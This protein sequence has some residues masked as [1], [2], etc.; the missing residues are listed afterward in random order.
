MRRT[1]VLVA[2]VPSLLLTLCAGCGGCQARPYAYPMSSKVPLG[3]SETPR[4]YGDTVVDFD[5]AFWIPSVKLRRA[6]VPGDTITLATSD[7][8]RY[9]Q[10]DGTEIPLRPPLPWLGGNCA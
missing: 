2:W 9:V 5:H 7:T 6:C 10:A 8:A 1:T 4:C 3:T